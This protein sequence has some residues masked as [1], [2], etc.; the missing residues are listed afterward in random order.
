LRRPGRLGRAIHL[1]V[2]PVRPQSAFAQGIPRDV[3]MAIRIDRCG[4]WPVGQPPPPLPA[5]QADVRS[6]LSGDEPF[7]D[8]LDLQGLDEGGERV[9]LAT[10]HPDDTVELTP[11]GDQPCLVV[12][13]RIRCRLEVSVRP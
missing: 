1:N 13:Q 6:R 12:G 11:E 4:R 8:F 7:D 5:V 3:L 2:F 10:G 9:R